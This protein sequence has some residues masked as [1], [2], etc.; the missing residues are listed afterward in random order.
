MQLTRALL[1]LGVLSGL[2]FCAVCVFGSLIDW[3]ELR[4]A[5]AAFSA[6]QHAD[7]KTIFVAE[8]HQNIHR[9][10]LFADVVWA[11]LS[12]I[13]AVVSASG[14]AILRRLEKK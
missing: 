13:L 4:H 14:L 5:Y 8:A 1:W 2:V 11:L 7:L 9:I 10:N 3:R 6:S 12:A